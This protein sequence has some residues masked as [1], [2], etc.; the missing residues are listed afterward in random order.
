CALDQGRDVLAVPG[1]VL[2]T[3]NKGGHAL[4]RD[5][6]RI[7]ESV[8]DVLE[9]L[10]MS[11]VATRFGAL[12]A[13]ACNSDATDAVLASLTPGESCDLDAIVA[14]S[15]LSPARLLS[16]LLELEL[17]GRVRRSGGGGFIRVDSSC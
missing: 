14:R 4:L 16:L 3:R 11:A 10:N 7:A 8:D 1:N 2:S 5:G 9:E 12:G 17:Q 13:G 6:A 15:G